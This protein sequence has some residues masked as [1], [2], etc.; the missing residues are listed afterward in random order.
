MYH[1]VKY[2]CLSDQNHKSH[3]HTELVS[4][5]RELWP[6]RSEATWEVCSV[7]SPH[8]TDP[9]GRL[10]SPPG[11]SAGTTAWSPGYLLKN[12]KNK[13]QNHVRMICHTPVAPPYRNDQAAQWVRTWDFRS[14]RHVTHI[15]DEWSAA[16]TGRRWVVDTTERRECTH[17]TI[18]CWAPLWLR[19]L[20]PLWT[21]TATVWWLYRGYYCNH[22]IT[23]SVNV[24]Y[25][26]KVLGR[27]LRNYRYVSISDNSFHNT[28]LII[29]YFY[30]SQTFMASVPHP[31]SCRW[32]FTI[33]VSVCTYS[34]AW[35]WSG[36]SCCSHQHLW[37]D[38]SNTDTVDDIVTVTEVK[39]W[40]SFFKKSPSL[41]C[42]VNIILL[43]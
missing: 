33:S 4:D 34:D 23:V 10:P 39:F 41:V 16:Q 35:W 27:C 9:S 14:T 22:M 11:T 40:K 12:K 19:S 43:Y 32:K 18:W 2:C 25:G 26:A 20:G 1:T 6:D 42:F 17:Q 30:N 29:L 15:K 3:R 28:V 36:P 8:D 38:L 37:L 21:G 7:A 24:T 31:F 13:K 5:S